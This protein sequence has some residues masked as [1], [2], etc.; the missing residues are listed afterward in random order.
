MTAPSALDL[1]RGAAFNGEPGILAFR[2]PIFTCEAGIWER[3]ELAARGPAGTLV[4]SEAYEGGGA[5][6]LLRKDER[7]AGR[8]G[9]SMVYEAPLYRDIEVD[10]DDAAL[11]LCEAAAAVRAKWKAGARLD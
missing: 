8:T 2:A 7:E 9:L 6:S 10:D 4:S 1:V 11:V 5:F 3:S